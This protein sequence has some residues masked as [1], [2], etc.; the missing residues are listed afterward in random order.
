MMKELLLWITRKVEI[1]EAGLVSNPV[2][3]DSEFYS[4]SSTVPSEKEGKKKPQ[5]QPTELP[6]PLKMAAP[7][8]PALLLVAR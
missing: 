2:E 4:V 3:V 1:K 5:T 7:D 6:V 8:R